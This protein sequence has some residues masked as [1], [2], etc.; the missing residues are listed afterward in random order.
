MEMPPAIG[1]PSVWYGPDFVDRTEW[2]EP[3]SSDVKRGR[4]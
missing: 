1:G 3:F 4:S 2:I